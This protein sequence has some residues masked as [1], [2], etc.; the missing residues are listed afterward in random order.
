M[1]TVTIPRAVLWFLFTATLWA[2]AG[3]ARAG[4]SDEAARGQAKEHF[5]RGSHLFENGDNAGALAEFEKAHQLV[6]NKRVVYNI[7]M[8]YA[9]MG[10]PVEA[11]QFL[12]EVLSDPGP[13]SPEQLARARDAKEEQTRRIG[14]INVKVNVPA[15]IEV[16]GEH[17]RDASSEAP[18][19]VAAGGHVVAAIAPGYLPVR[20]SVAV[21]GQAHV[22]M[23]LELQPTGGKLAQVQ[24][25]CLLPGAEVLVDDVPVGKTPLAEPVTVAPGKRVFELQR[26]GYMTIRREVTLSDGAHR[27]VAFKPEEDLQAGDARG[28]MR[29]LASEDSVQ[30]TVD[31]QSRGAYRKAIELPAG[32]HIVKLEKAGFE[33]L[34]RLADVPAGS[35]VDVKVTLRP[36]LET[37]DAYLSHARAYR[38]WSVAALVTGA[39][40]AGGS[41]ALALWGNSKLP[42]ANDNL[43]KVNAENVANGCNATNIPDIRRL[44]CEQNLAA[45]Q[46]DVDKYTN[47]RLG[48]IIGA[49]AGAAIIG[50]GVVLWL[51]GPDPGI[52]D[53]PNAYAS[54]L[55][56]VLAA[57]PDGASLMLRGRF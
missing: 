6:P 19:R 8:V 39:L 55:V 35:E 46:S 10:K 33:T 2:G 15:D 7:A 44:T 12:D 30:V 5:A 9:A 57:G 1:P 25:F 43:A 13:L 11:L 21:A 4:D 29:L 23:A 49:A 16:D 17:M 40:V 50:T 42:A 36:T 14:E 37:R 20:Q 41:V 54:T 52:Y 32:L 28:R 51:V 26:P 31:G 56:P 27:S 47:V 38:R 45:A 34:E 24:I 22:E 3:Q 48:G 53:R 18:I